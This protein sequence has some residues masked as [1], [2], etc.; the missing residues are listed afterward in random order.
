MKH[1]TSTEGNR[2]NCFSEPRAAATTV[3]EQMALRLF[4]SR[5]SNW[6]ESNKNPEKHVSSCGKEFSLCKKLFITLH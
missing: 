5:D 4:Q 6:Q 3:A 2:N 1:I